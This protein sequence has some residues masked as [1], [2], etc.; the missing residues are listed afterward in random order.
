[1][2]G[3]SRNRSPSTDEPPL[4]VIGF[5]RSGTTLVRLMLDNHPRLAI[6]LD[7]VGLWAR[8]YGR[9]EHYNRLTADADVESLVRDVLGEERLRLWQVDL[10]T[11]DILSQVRGHTFP[12]V[13]AAFYLAYA[14]SKGKSR[15][16]DKDPGNMSRIHLI[17]LWFPDSRVLHIV[18]DGRDAC[19]SHTRQSFG[20]DHVLT[21]ADAWREQV[22]W[23]RRIG[24]ILGPQR[25]MEIR[26]EDLLRSPEETLRDVC[27]FLALDYSNRMLKYYE[28]VDESIPASKRHIWPL[29]DRPVQRGN[30]G[31]WKSEMSDGLRLCFEKRAGPLLEELGYE[32][33][34]GTRS[35]AYLE[36]A[37][38]W[39]HTIRQALRRRLVRR[40]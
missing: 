39:L 12:D 28:R 37:K 2:A 29:I 27:S 36:E 17:N 18:R 34:P 16:G 24:L 6:P 21:C 40:G 38:L 23:V 32:V 19:L 11:S 7:V 5:Q 15:W 33:L 8:Y 25:Y 26:Y 9:L 1:M 20:F 31:R 14:Q 30:A 10:T 13:V 4:F 3:L 35:G 22:E